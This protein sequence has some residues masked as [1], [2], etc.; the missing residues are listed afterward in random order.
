MSL[1]VLNVAK[2]HLKEFL[3]SESFF[4]FQMFSEYYFIAF[5]PQI[6]IHTNEFAKLN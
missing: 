1:S 6:N 2:A 5:I 4:L 3:A